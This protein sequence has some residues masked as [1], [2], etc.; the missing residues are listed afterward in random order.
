[1]ADVVVTF[2]YF[3]VNVLNAIY[4]TLIKCFANWK[5]ID[6][7]IKDNP[8]IMLW[9]KMLP[10]SLASTLHSFET[11]FVLIVLEN[12]ATRIIKTNGISK[13]SPRFFFGEM[14]NYKMNQGDFAQLLSIHYVSS[15]RS[16]LSKQFW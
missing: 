2:F 10:K 9:E 4:I 6:T 16:V 12:Y 1:M 14:S 5:C 15:E 7:V 8:I 13:V 11:L 3:V